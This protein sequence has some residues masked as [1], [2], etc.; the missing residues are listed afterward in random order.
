MCDAQTALARDRGEYDRICEV[1]F[2]HLAGLAQLIVAM[3]VPTQDV[4]DVAAEVLAHFFLNVARLTP[5]PHARALVNTIARRRIADYYRVPDA[6][7]QSVPLEDDHQDI[8]MASASDS[9]VIGEIL[10]NEIIQQLPEQLRDVA[11]ARFV[12]YL[13]VARTA[14]ELHLSIDVVKKRSVD[15]E[16]RLRQII[17][18]GG[19]RFE[20]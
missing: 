14:S 2:A 19:Y 4:Q 13:G 12:A 7:T 3:K 15:A 20:H 16:R 1:L 5:I 17:E 10:T 18:G 9:E 8:V 6:A 11:R